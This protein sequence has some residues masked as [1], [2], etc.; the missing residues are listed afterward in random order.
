MSSSSCC[1]STV[2]GFFSSRAARGLAAQVAEL[3]L[4]SESVV[5]PGGRLVR[6]SEAGGRTAVIH[7]KLTLKY[8][9]SNEILV[10][11]PVVAAE[12]LREAGCCRTE[13]AIAGR[14]RRCPSS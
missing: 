5:R 4:Q 1:L 8:G 2:T 13:P 10:Q 9:P 6:R 11:R 12:G 7:E 3:V 14:R